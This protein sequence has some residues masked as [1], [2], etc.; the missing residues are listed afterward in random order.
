MTV[1]N[2]ALEAYIA[3]LDEDTSP[4]VY[5]DLLLEYDA[6]AAGMKKVKITTIAAPPSEGGGADYIL[7]RDEK[8]QNTPGGT[9]TT[10]A[11]RTRD[12]NV[13]VS[14]LG[15]HVTLAANQFTLEAGTYIINAA[16][17]AFSV[18]Q[19]KTRLYN[20]S[21]S[22]E[23]T[24]TYGSSAYSN[25]GYST[26]N[27][28]FISGVFTISS[29]KIFEIQHQGSTTIADEGFGVETNFGVEVYTIVEL[30]KI[31]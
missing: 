29:P 5:N 21:D 26:Q 20:I 2:S 30:W 14:D 9:F 23:Q 3:S 17:P 25:S 31:G 1:T 12:L 27:H 15:N 8:T 10:G 28:S 16:A 11:W 13:E 6:S 4:D 22:V 19:H 18:N 7:L 24:G